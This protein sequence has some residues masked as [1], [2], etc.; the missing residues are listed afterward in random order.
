MFLTYLAVIKDQYVELR[1]HFSNLMSHQAILDSFK[2]AS[3]NNSRGITF[4][5]ILLCVKC[6]IKLKKTQTEYYGG[7]INNQS[8]SHH[9]SAACF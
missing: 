9:T 6:E 1:G 3:K 2:K 8:Y 5:K 4:E 7:E